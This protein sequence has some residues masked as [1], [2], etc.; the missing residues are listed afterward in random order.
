MTIKAELH[1][2]VFVFC[3]FGEEGVC[4]LLFC[5]LFFGNA[6]IEETQKKMD[7]EETSSVLKNDAT[8]TKQN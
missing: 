1:S 4:V 7:C 6:W 2:R 3:F 8:P 5:F